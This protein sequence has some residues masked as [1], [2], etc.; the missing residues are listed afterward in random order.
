M[1]THRRFSRRGA[2]V[3]LAAWV[4]ALAI[5]VIGI[6]TA[7]DPARAQAIHGHGDRDR[8][9]ITDHTLEWPSREKLARV[10]LLRDYNTRVVVGGV[11]LLGLAAGVIGT[12]LLLRK[13]SLTADALSHATLPGIAIAFMLAVL[14][15][16]DGKQLG[17]LLA[18]AFVFGLLGMGMILAIRNTTRIK[19]DAALGI[20][21]SVFFGL[22]AALVKLAEELP[23]G[24]AAGLDR[25]ILGRAASMLGSDAQLILWAAIAITVVTAL[26]FKEFKLLCFDESF[27]ASQGMRV[28]LLDAVLMGLVVGVTVIGLQSVGLVLVV[29]L[30]ITPAAAARFW[31]DHLHVMTAVS[32]GVGVFSGYFGAVASALWPR[33]PTGPI[34]VLVCSAAF[35]FSLIFGLRRGLIVRTLRNFMLTQRVTMQNL[36]RALFELSEGDAALSHRA[37]GITH[38]LPDVPFDRIVAHRSWPAR[39]VRWQLWIARARGLVV[40]DHAGAYRLTRFGFSEAR[41]IVRNHRLWEI[42]LIT[43]AEIAPSH[44][45]RDADHI[46][47]VLDPDLI[48]RLEALL[49][50]QFPHLV[51]PESPHFVEETR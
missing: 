14:A 33:V 28:V 1:S 5:G 46:E 27:A 15:G 25:F 51:V 24:S 40:E 6:A 10:L 19:D 18:G 23:G 47:H 49:A 30:L 3:L 26:L 38:P 39:T 17:V 50:A 32:A 45:D 4:V 42:Y 16:G 12:F 8:D 21:L 2:A 9:S 31:T 7:P 35:V 13:R 48:D 37:N 43:H 11:T 22:G 41:R 29:A 34:I 44:V 20:V 36:L